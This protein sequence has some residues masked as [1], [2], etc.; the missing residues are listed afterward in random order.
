M[1]RTL[2]KSYRQA[3]G[4]WR[5]YPALREAKLNFVQIAA[6]INFERQPSLAWGF[7]GHR[8]QLYRRTV[9]H[10]GFEML[11][12]YAAGLPHGAFVVT[13]NVDGQFQK[14]GYAADRLWEI[15]GS[16]HYLQCLR[17]CSAAI[18]P[19]A[20]FDPSI[21]ET[22]CRLT[23]DLPRCPH[24]GAVARPNIL[25]FDDD[26][27]LDARNAAQQRHFDYWRSRPKNLVINSAS[28]GS[29][30]IAAAR[31][32]SIDGCCSLAQR[33]L[34]YR[35]AFCSMVSNSIY[36]AS[37]TRRLRPEVGSIRH[38]LSRTGSALPGVSRRLDGATDFILIEICRLICSA[39]GKSSAPGWRLSKLQILK[40]PS[41]KTSPSNCCLA[42]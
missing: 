2:D 11:K 5:A 18:W 39:A 30:C 31:F 35:R 3:A 42:Q 10:A 23:S 15:H 26:G 28:D 20:A 22:R 14:A 9:P 38:A 21:D 17:P 25:M 19:A 13:G 34:D 36:W 7:Y 4:F 16:I 1:N 8:L 29:S 41:N 40:T 32:F 33:N 37:R 24:C 27:Y 12:N 6:P